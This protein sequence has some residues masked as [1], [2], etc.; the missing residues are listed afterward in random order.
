V[1]ANRFVNALPPARKETDP[2]NDLPFALFGVLKRQE[3]TPLAAFGPPFVF[4]PPREA[5][6]VTPVGRRVE[7]PFVTRTDATTLEPAFG[8][9]GESFTE[10]AATFAEL[11]PP[12]PLRRL[13]RPSGG[14][15]T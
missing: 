4:T 7:P 2:A 6:H 3:A 9:A 15:G 10:P 11:P 8:F 12:P 5:A 1:T 13:L 14:P